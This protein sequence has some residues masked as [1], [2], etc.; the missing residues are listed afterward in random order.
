MSCLKNFPIDELIID[1]SFV[2]DIAHDRSDKAIASAIIS[3]GKKLNLNIIGEGVEM[4]HQIKLLNELGCN[5]MQGYLFGKAQ[6]AESITLRVYLPPLNL[7]YVDLIIFRSKR[8][9]LSQN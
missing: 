3:L 2:R 4:E 6:S 9:D 1:R 7:R 8:R 5:V